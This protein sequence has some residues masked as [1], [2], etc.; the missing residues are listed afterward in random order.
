MNNEK[1]ISFSTDNSFSKN[2]QEFKFRRQNDKALTHINTGKEIWY[3]KNE[4]LKDIKNLEKTLTDKFN[5]TDFDRKEEIKALNED[6]SSLNVK[7]KE[8]STKITEDNSIKEKINNFDSVKA[9]ILDSILIN[10]VKVNNLDREIRESISDMKSILKETVIYAGVIGPSCKFKTFHDLLDFFINEIKILSISR[11]KNMLDLTSFKKR[12]ETNV[13]G[14]KI[15]LESFGRSSTKFTMDNFNKIDKDMNELFHKCNDKI[16]DIKSNFD[17]KLRKLDDKIDEIKIKLVKEINEIKDKIESLEKSNNNNIELY[18][19][20]K[21]DINKLNENVV[22]RPKRNSIMNN[23]NSIDTNNTNNNI[24]K[25]KINTKRSI[26]RN[27]K[28]EELKNNNTNSTTNINKEAKDININNNRN[29]NSD[30]TNNN[31]NKNENNLPK[32]DSEDDMNESDKINSIYNKR[33]NQENIKILKD[34]S[35][36]I[37]LKKDLKIDVESLNTFNLNKY[38][39]NKT[40][41]KKNE[42]ENN[43]DYNKRRLLL[44]DIG[45]EDIKQKSFSPK[46][47]SIKIKNM[48]NN[49]NVSNHSDETDNSK[50]S[51]KTIV[52]TKNF[53][54]IKSL[55]ILNESQNKKDKEKKNIILNL[56]TPTTDKNIFNKNIKI[57]KEQNKHWFN[58]KG[59]RNI[60][61]RKSIN[62]IN[63][64]NIENNNNKNIL[65]ERYNLIYQRTAKSST[66]FK[67]IMLTLEGTKKMIYETKDFHKG[68]NLYHIESLSDTNKKK[69]YLRE[70]LESCKPYLINKLYKNQMSSYFLSGKEE[71]YDFI[72]YKN[73]RL[74]LNKSASSKIYLKNKHS[75]DYEQKRN[76]INNYLS[77]SLQ[78]SKYV[79]PK[80]N[81]IKYSEEK[82]LQTEKNYKIKDIK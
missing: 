24:N 33:K 12:I 82:S 52:N 51:L 42:M 1:R 71:V 67:N 18:Q 80:K 45:L 32:I 55:N 5:S 21:D 59:K 63:S 41:K 40:M 4:I 36:L 9:K 64:L 23:L 38:V 16:D 44:S 69:S 26:L 73:H 74:M 34:N 66:K 2:P 57:F 10:D 29:D 3:F 76:N 19:N 6:V 79:P 46:R 17:E 11:E 43:S 15:Q 49:F 56:K 70:R 77:P 25:N 81:N 72:K 65:N 48:K 8:L 22:K 68:K 39:M 37:N 30:N 7:L 14:F 53:E 75:A 27:D 28:I 54:M 47:K 35:D 62:A 50:L 78:V 13:Q 58:D 61:R 31:T 60:K 20:L